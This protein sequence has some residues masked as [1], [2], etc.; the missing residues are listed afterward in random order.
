L[1]G[2]RPVSG[3]VWP[4]TPVAVTVTVSNGVVMMSPAD[5]VP[6][7]HFADEQAAAKI[8]TAEA[9]PLV[10]PALSAEVGPLSGLPCWLQVAPPLTVATT[11]PPAPPAKQA[12]SLTQA[13]ADSDCRLL[14]ACEGSCAGQV[15]PL[16]VEVMILACVPVPPL[17]PTT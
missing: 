11:V 5:A 16:S 10:V 12:T 15:W 1:S 2:E 7:A 14:L 17:A 8:A 13:I 4:N 6:N 3:G 9:G